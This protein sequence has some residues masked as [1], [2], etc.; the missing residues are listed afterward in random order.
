M[1]L[2]HPDPPFTP[3]ARLQPLFRHIHLNYVSLLHLKVRDI[4]AHSGKLL[5]IGNLHFIDPE[6]AE[7]VKF[8][9]VEELKV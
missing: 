7:L 2:Q 5:L 8:E 1:L 9:G 3:L 6:W 4:M